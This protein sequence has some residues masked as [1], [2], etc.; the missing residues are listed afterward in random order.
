MLLGIHWIYIVIIG[1]T[2]NVLVNFGFK[3]FA[4]KPES[5][6]FSSC[7]YV[8]TAITICTYAILNNTFHPSVVASTKNILI[9]LMTGIGLGTM[10]VFFVTALD[11]GPFGLVNASWMAWTMVL[12]LIAGV[13]IYKDAITWQGMMGAG[14]TLVG[15]F[16][17]AKS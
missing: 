7:I 12:S 14:L 17:M 6:L 13:L 2:L 11:R 4:D 5:F 15:L 1:A 16:F 9:I 3:F 10:I 8:V